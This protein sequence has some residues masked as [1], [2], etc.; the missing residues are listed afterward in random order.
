MGKGKV[1]KVCEQCSI[2]NQREYEQMYISPYI[3]KEEMLEEEIK[4]N[5]D[6]RGIFVDLTLKPS[7]Y[8]T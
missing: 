3:N 8:F 7:K 4:E 1:G 2:F 6:L 5:G